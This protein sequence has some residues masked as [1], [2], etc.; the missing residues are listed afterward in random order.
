MNFH[1]S[2]KSDLLVS[3][4]SPI[5]CA[6]TWIEDYLRELSNLLTHEFKDYEIVLIANE[7]NHHTI[8]IIERLQTELR[9]IQLYCLT[10]PVPYE[11]A[12]VVGL[13]NAVGDLVITMDAAYDPCGPIAQMAYMSYEGYEIVYGLRSDRIKSRFDVY[14]LL[15]RLFFRFYCY[16]TKEDLPIAASTLRLYTRQAT[17]SFLDNSDRYSLFPVIGAFSGLRYSTL[18]YHRISRTG[19][20]QKQSYRAAC[21]RAL[22]L[23]FLSS[24]YP[25]R[26][27]STVALLGAFLNV[28]YSAYVIF[29]NLFK[30]NVT[31]GWTTLSL[32]ISIMFFML[33]MILA[34]L[35]EYISRLFLSNQNRP[36]YL[37]KKERV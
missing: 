18:S 7:T 15:S 28:F 2:E 26:V 21:A 33:F 6:E 25:L 27:L 12:F 22:S 10:R 32:Q 1:S 19:K 37:I 8:S 31:E 5:S 30:E 13:E 24:Y 29:V 34:V 20:A 4:I 11:T 14:H 35:S 16:I 3:V 23:I 9:N 17:N 36:P